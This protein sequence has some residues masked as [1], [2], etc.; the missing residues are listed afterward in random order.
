MNEVLVLNH[1]KSTIN[2]V[3]LACVFDIEF[4]R[5]DTGIK[6]WKSQS[7]NE[8][9]PHFLSPAHAK[10]VRWYHNRDMYLKFFWLK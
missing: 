1:K 5:L 2:D 10:T 8:I 7:Q 6:P 9:S 3:Q 4:D